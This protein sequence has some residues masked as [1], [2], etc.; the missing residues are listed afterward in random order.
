MLF[1]WLFVGRV[2]MK[3]IE[4]HGQQNIKYLTLFAS[5]QTIQHQTVTSSCLPHNELLR[6]WSKA[7]VTCWWVLLRVWLGDNCGRL[8]SVEG[9]REDVRNPTRPWQEV[10]EMPTDWLKSLTFYS[11]LLSSG[12]E[13]ILLHRNPV[14]LPTTKSSFLHILR[15]V[16]VKTQLIYC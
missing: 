4:M 10:M 2:G 7:L 8:Q 16:S 14:R 6:I 13:G 11:S 15:V 3:C 1:S 5:S 9:P 12:T